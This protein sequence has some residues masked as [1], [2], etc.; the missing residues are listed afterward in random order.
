LESTS[1]LLLIG[2]Y[3]VNR[4]SCPTITEIFDY[5][6]ARHDVL[7]QHGMATRDN[8]A[9]WISP[10]TGWQPQRSDKGIEI[11]LYRLNKPILFNPSQKIRD[12]V[13]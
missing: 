13:A 3:A 7:Y 11:L 10:G 4:V 5:V 1:A 2:F 6:P 9:I 8:M 12:R